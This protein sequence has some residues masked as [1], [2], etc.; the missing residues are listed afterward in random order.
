V[1]LSLNRQRWVNEAYA[2]AKA[3]TTFLA[4]MSHEIRTPMN[5]IIGMTS[6]LLD[7]NLTPEQK[8]C[9]EVIR[10]GGEHLLTV[11][12]DILDFSKIEAGKVELEIQAFSLRDCVES[13]MDLLS[14]AANDKTVGLGYLIHGGVPEGLLGDVGRL[15]QVLVNLLSNAVKFTP[16]GGEVLIEVKSIS[17]ELNQYEVEFSISDTGIGLS[18]D[19]ISRLFQPFMQAEISTTRISGGTGLGLSISKRLVE[20][21]GGQISVESQLGK[22]S[23]FKFKIQSKT[24]ALQ[25]RATTNKEISP[26]LNNLR[27]LV[28]DDLEINRRILVHYTKLWGMSVVSCESSSEATNLIA[29]GERFDLALLD[30]QM[31]NEN[32]LIL[33]QSLKESHNPKKLPIIILSSAMVDIQNEAAISTSILKPIK[34]SKLLEAI[35][36]VFSTNT[37]VST[38]EVSESK[39]PHD[40]ATRFPLSILIAEDNQINQL[41]IKMLLSRMGYRPDFA[42]DGEETIAS[43][44]RQNYDVI[45]MD[46]QM[47]NMDGLEATRFL[48]ANLNQTVRPRIV[49]MTAD[50]LPEHELE[51]KQ[52]GMDDFVPKPVKVESLVSALER[53]ARPSH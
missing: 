2:A 3:K 22:G 18:A 5:A 29:K 32:G 36:K 7:T 23:V 30:F 26:N 6:I 20:L 37:I 15:R 41:I 52:A 39:I 43:V 48:C 1:Q 31:P 28:V 17:Q 34:P 9:A 45:F 14:K 35:N 8:E 51:C 50:V 40:L 25:N 16:S 24:A 53:C 13:A 49:G 33:A 10:G 12:N 21:M 46:V 44:E 19:A 38:N 4:S 11:I 42:A 27:V 47:P